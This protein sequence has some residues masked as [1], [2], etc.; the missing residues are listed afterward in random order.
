MAMLR[1]RNIFDARISGLGKDARDCRE[2]QQNIPSSYI[3]LAPVH[4]LTLR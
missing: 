4:A 1:P 3:E 2:V